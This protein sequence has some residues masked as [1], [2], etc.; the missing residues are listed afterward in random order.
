MRRMALSIKESGRVDF[1]LCVGDDH[2]DEAMFAT[3]KEAQNK[4]LDGSVGDENE[5]FHKDTMFYTCHIGTDKS[6]V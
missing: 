2:A 6:Q 4:L 3:I 5:V 1:L